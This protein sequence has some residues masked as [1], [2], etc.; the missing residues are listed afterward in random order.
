MFRLVKQFMCYGVC[1]GIPFLFIN[2]FSLAD[3]P[4]TIYT[5]EGKP[6]TALLLNEFTQYWIEYYN[7]IGDQYVEDFNLDAERIGDASQ[8]YNCHAYAWRVS[9]G[10]SKV[11]INT[12]G[13]DAYW[14]DASYAHDGN[15]SYS[16]CSESQATHVSYV[17]D[18]HST[19]QEEYNSS[20]PDDSWYVS[21]WGPWGLYRH[22]KGQDPYDE[23]DYSF[24]KLKSSLLSHSSSCMS[25]SNR[26]TWLG[27]DLMGFFPNRTH[28]LSLDSH[29]AH[30]S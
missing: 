5:P 2:S 30:N 22:K 9:E 21:K 27:E 6:I 25:G 17:G 4:V 28:S 11:W 23:T 29:V 10:G 26:K 19:R 16:S 14:T 18:D 3:S 12:P 15:P 1:I 13:D 24:Y 20:N 7:D 8:T